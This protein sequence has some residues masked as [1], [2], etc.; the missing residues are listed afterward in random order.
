MYTSKTNSMVVSSV[1]SIEPFT[2]R[3]KGTILTSNDGG[4]NLAECRYSHLP[5][6]LGM[7]LPRARRHLDR[8]GGLVQFSISPHLFE[9][10]DN[11]L[12][13]SA[14]AIPCGPLRSIALSKSLEFWRQLHRVDSLLVDRLGRCY[15]TTDQTSHFQPDGDWQPHRTTPM[16]FCK[17]DG[18]PLVVGWRERAACMS[19]QDGQ[20][21][22][23]KRILP[24][25][26]PGS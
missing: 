21:A 23:N 24:G 19:L 3:S 10:F 6:L 13:W 16:L 17:H 14:I 2:H 1:G 9:S 20:S 18:K 11:G 25:S 8:V 15:T 7:R 12:T 4:S 22:G 26:P 5:R